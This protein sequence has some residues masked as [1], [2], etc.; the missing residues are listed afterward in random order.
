MPDENKELTS[1]TH[2]NSMEKNVLLYLHDLVSSTVRP[3]QEL[4][5][6]EKIELQAGETK[7]VIFEITEPMLRL[8]NPCNE[9][10]SEKGDF[11]ISVGYADHMKFTETFRLI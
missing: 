8:W 6:F 5:A 4:V 1:G 11:T 3:I 10:V 7:T 9:F 2:V